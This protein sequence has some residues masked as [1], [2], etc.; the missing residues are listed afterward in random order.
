MGISVQNIGNNFTFNSPYVTNSEKY[1]SSYSNVVEIGRS[2]S[3]D[4]QKTGSITPKGTSDISILA[5]AP[6]P[7]VKIQGKIKNAK[8]VV[9]LSKNVLYFY[10]DN[11]NPLCAYLISSGKSSTPTSTGVR[12]VSHVET[13]PYNTAPKSS[14]RRRSPGAYGPKIIIL[15][16]LDPKTGE[17]SP[18]GEFIHGNNAP[19]DLGKYVSHGCMRMDNEVIKK[20]SGLV[21]RGDIVNI[22]K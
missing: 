13:Y 15:D 9:N 10:D 20:L 5:K 14:K 18:I 21:K 1:S 3:D 17:I 11:G 12:R 22:I 6:S 2:N 8:I 16:I 7:K 4:T 19:A